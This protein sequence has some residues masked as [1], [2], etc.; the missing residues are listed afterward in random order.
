MLDRLLVIFS[1][2]DG[3]RTSND[4]KEPRVKVM[5]DSFIETCGDPSKVHA[6]LLDN[7]STDGSE[8]I[9]QDYQSDTWTYRRKT[10][11]DYYL[12]TLNKLLHEY[13]GQYDYMMVIDNDQYFFRPNY[14]ERTLQIFEDEPEIIAVHLKEH[15][16]N[17]DLD[18]H[19][20]SKGIAGIY[21]KIC[22]VL[23]SYWGR[24]PIF[25]PTDPFF[26][27]SPD[28]RGMGVVDLAGFAPKRV[29]WMYYGYSNVVIR[30][31]PFV[32]VFKRK[33]LELPFKSNP[34]RLA[35]FSSTAT[36]F[37]RS[38]QL[39][40]GA[41]INFGFRKHIKPD[42]S[43]KKMI[44]DYKKGYGSLNMSDKYSFYYDNGRLGPVSRQVRALA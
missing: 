40:E 33:G 11:E 31:D 23:G 32:E 25:E 2:Y 29:C 38:A 10:T 13:Q 9:L 15:T 36:R 4:L 12:G 19:P 42:V 8:E 35:L 5:I 18:S 1:N 6:L 24:A 26:K 21:D 20:G 44:K 43:V 7:G 39:L 34:D 17:E 41:S 16:K 37:G 28:K 27:P 30:T 14:L 3:Y 22:P